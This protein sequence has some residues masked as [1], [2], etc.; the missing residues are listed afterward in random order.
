MER[1]LQLLSDA[2]D[3][4]IVILNAACALYVAEKVSSI[5]DGITLAKDSIDSGKALAK[6]EELKIFTNGFIS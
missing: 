4:D 1:F 6:L 2:V 5:S 3:R